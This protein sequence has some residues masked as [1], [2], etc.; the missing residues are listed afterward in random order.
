[1]RTQLDTLDQVQCERNRRVL[2]PEVRIEIGGD[3]VTTET[4]L[5]AEF[6]AVLRRLTLKQIWY[7]VARRK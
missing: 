3:H 1:M 6:E 2:V 4:H 5:M 7:V